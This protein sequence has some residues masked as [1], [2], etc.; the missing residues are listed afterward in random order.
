MHMLTNFSFFEQDLYYTDI[1]QTKD[2]NHSFQNT[3]T[4]LVEDYKKLNYLS[5]KDPKPWYIRKLKPILNIKKGGSRILKPFSLIK[6]T[7]NS[8]KFEF[9]LSKIT[10]N[11]GRSAL[12]FLSNFLRS[13]SSHVSKSF[14]FLRSVKGGAICYSGGSVGF[15]P[16]KQAGRLYRDICVLDSNSIKLLQFFY[17]L[18]SKKHILKRLF[19]VRF[20]FKF[21]NGKLSAKRK[22]KKF[23]LSS[24]KRQRRRRRKSK[25]NRVFLISTKKISRPRK[26]FLKPSLLQTCSSNLGTFSLSSENKKILWK[27]K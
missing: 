8:L 2:L 9:F 10:G 18:F 27:N 7:Q 6:Q 1:L 5:Y 3:Q 23:S 19:V 14:I 15:L 24:K 16:R 20:P 22:K 21:V 26:F 17:L 11:T 13:T 4:I 25:L 12:I